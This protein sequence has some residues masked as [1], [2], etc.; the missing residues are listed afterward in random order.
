MKEKYISP[1]AIDLGAKNTGVYF[2]HYKAGSSIGE[3]D[4]EGKVYQLEKDKYTLLMANRT[5]VRH[6]RR[7]YDRKQMV[8]R[9]FKLI[10][11]EHFKLTW[12]DKAQ[13]SISF[14][15]NRRGF[16]FLTEEYNAEVLSRFPKEA[17]DKLP[18]LVR[19]KFDNS[20]SDTYDFAEKLTEWVQD[21]TE[22]KRYFEEINKEP[23]QIRKRLVVISH[24][25]K[26]SE[27]CKTRLDHD[28]VQEKERARPNLARLS[29]WILNEWKNEGIKG[30]DTI[31][32]E[33]GKWPNILKFRNDLIPGK[34]RMITLK[35]FAEEYGELIDY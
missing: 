1:I 3:I 34:T 23:E 9:L 25:K 4:K 27:Y 26:L 17:F 11:E 5:A 35:A 18:S 2:A 32:N 10:W 16:S 20:D 6:Q 30:L 12:D 31:S 8:K 19:Q 29:N 7:G 21:E 13:Q 24:T 33:A 28:T 14:L 15:L 22:I